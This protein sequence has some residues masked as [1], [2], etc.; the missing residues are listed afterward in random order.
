MPAIEQWH[1][2][3]WGILSLRKTGLELRNAQKKSLKIF[4]IK[5]GVLDVTIAIYIV[6]ILS[7][8]SQGNKRRRC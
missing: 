4:M 7:D 6:I 2:M 8:V 1:C 3:I 5:S